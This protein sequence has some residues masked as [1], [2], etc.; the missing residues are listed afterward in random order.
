MD[1]SKQK[2]LDEDTKA[3]QQIGFT[4][5]APNNTVRIYYIV[6]QSKETMFEFSEG[7]TKVL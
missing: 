3:I 5:Q 7:T 1:L 4:G 2:A 6:E